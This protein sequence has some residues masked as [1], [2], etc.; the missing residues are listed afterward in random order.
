MAISIHLSSDDLAET[1]FAFS[2][3]WELG[4]SLYKALRD[5]SRHALHL[6]W[7]QDAMRAI[8]G[9]DLEIL[10]AVVPPLERG[11]QVHPYIPDFL[12]PAPE[13]P[14]PQFEDELDQ[15][16]DTDP[17]RIS[18]ELRHMI[19]S[20]EG[21]PTPALTQE[22]LDDPAPYLGRLVEQMREYWKLT[23][24]PHWPRIRALHEADVTYRARQLALGGAELLFADLHPSLTWEGDSLV[25]DKHHCEDIEP[26]GRGL[27]LIPAVFD[28]PGIA[29]LVGEGLQPTLAYSPRGIAELWDEPEDTRADGAMDDLIG[30]TRA[31]LL[32]V[33]SVPM[34]T[35]E[36]AHRLHLTPAAVSQ[37]LGVLRR[38][39]VVDARRQGREVYSELTASGRRLLEL[40]G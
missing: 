28:W 16:A 14:F 7:V 31:D 35:G 18:A 12:T 17:A 23:I 1:R 6:P 22:I 10:F 21:V 24:E 20:L 33:L 32:R 8:E 2:P 26:G 15:V 19:D 40:L 27:V 5:P 11:S 39:G 37:Q 4:M 36:L 29:V 3:I 38:A 30:G 34:T 13:T 25:I 9:R